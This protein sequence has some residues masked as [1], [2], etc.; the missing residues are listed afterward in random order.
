MIPNLGI[1]MENSQM[2]KNTSVL[3]GDHFEHFIAKEVASG[4]YGSA[5]EVVRE[6]LRLLEHEVE[7]RNALIKALEL[8]EKSGI[9]SDFD[10]EKHLNRLRE[11]KKKK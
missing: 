2:A 9:V 1:F 10:P 11:Q 4:R 3:L 5:S 6:A 7:K 8:G